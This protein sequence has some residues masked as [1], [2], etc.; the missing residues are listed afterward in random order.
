MEKLSGRAEIVEYLLRLFIV[1]RGMG[2]QGCFW[3]HVDGESRDGT[4]KYAC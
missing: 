4:L 2:R 3:I 1:A